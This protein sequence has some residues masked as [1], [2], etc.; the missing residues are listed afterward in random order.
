MSKNYFKITKF[1]DLFSSIFNKNSSIV[2]SNISKTLSKE[3]QILRNETNK[4]IKE[5]K[6]EELAFLMKNGYKL[7]SS[8]EQILTIEI[9]KKD[10]FLFDDPYNKERDNN[11]KK[12]DE[13]IKDGFVLPKEIIHIL[14]SDPHILIYG[15]YL[16]SKNQLITDENHIGYN[17][18]LHIYNVIIDH[19]NNNSDLLYKE[20]VNSLANE[21]DMFGQ[22]KFNIFIKNNLLKEKDKEKIFFLIELIKK[23]IDKEEKKEPPSCLQ[24]FK[25][26]DYN[27]MLTNLNILLED[28]NKSELN[29]LVNINK[30][31]SKNDGI[32]Y[33]LD[34]EYN[35]LPD[36]L[37]KNTVPLHF[38][39]IMNDISKNYD[40]LKKNK[41]DLDE[42][43]F[44]NIERMYHKQIPKVISMLNDSINL[45]D[46][47]KIKQ[48]DKL[49][50]EILLEINAK[51]LITLEKIKNFKISTLKSIH[52]HTKLN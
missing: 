32:N 48:A 26:K 29:N 8:Q 50:Q 27:S 33:L 31:L 22:Y 24:D 21:E 3:A 34:S 30:K 12:V 15:S 49:A 4:F 6:W 38:N 39:I 14:A 16:L 18:Y 10:L 51:F 45:G 9:L 36:F 5:G 1:I 23:Q 35:N 37:S 47:N 17:N 44:F 2:L 13:L 7:S 46:S 42:D 25:L 20:F 40:V 43:E 52:R 19:I 28:I 41:K 11:F